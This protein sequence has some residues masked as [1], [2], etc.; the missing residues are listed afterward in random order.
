VLFAAALWLLAPVDAGAQQERQ[1]AAAGSAAGTPATPA[2]T[3][4]AAP[5]APSWP[6]TLPDARAE[7]QAKAGPAPLPDA[8]SPAEIAAAKARCATLLAG[9]DV[10]AIPEEPIKQGT[11]GAPAPMQLLSIGRNPQVALSPPV[12]LS[13]EM[14]AALGTFVAS[15]MQPQARRLLGQ[16]IV[17]I[18][19][20][21]SYSCRTAYGRRG[22]RL[23]EHGR[24]NAIDVR[25][26]VGGNGDMV[27]LLADWGP[28]ARDIQAQV[29]AARAAEERAAA[30]RAAALAR[31][32]HGQPQSPPRLAA[33]PAVPTPPSAQPQPA[34]P[35]LGAGT[36]IEGLPSIAARLPGARPDPTDDQ[37]ALTFSPPSR[38]GG[39]QATT[40]PAPAAD[41]RTR[42]LRAVHAGACRIF[43]TVLGPEANNAHRNHFHFDMAERASGSYCE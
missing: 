1:P 37:R 42:F 11:C 5:L 27:E 13:C 7:A 28:T 16:P 14:I 34:A 8:W 30:E 20:M 15:E 43:G 23:S 31:A 38:L 32:Q 25:G 10:V 17:K 12:T 29:A 19:T 35:I 4:A 33:P 40:R 26:F 2:G 24:A 18:E 3:A 9:H 21:S 6:T 41:A 22:S 36:I 39:P